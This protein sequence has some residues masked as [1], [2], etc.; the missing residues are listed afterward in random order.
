MAESTRTLSLE[1]DAVHAPGD[2]IWMGHSVIP[3]DVAC[4]EVT[5]NLPS[6]PITS[7]AADGDMRKSAFIVNDLTKHPDLCT[8]PYVTGYPNGRFYA[9]VP[10]TTSSGVNIGAYCI[11]D[12]K[13]RDGVSDEDLVFLRDM[14][15]TV[16]THLE[17]VRA[18]SERQQIN[19][20]V[21]G[22]GDFVR[23]ASDAGR[24]APPATNMP[25][26][27]QAEAPAVQ[28]RLPDAL[29]EPT[30]T[31]AA[32]SNEAITGSFSPGHQSTSSRDHPPVSKISNVSERVGTGDLPKST[33]PLSNYA[34]RPMFH[35]QENADD[36][37]GTY[38]R[39][40]EILCQSLDIDGVAFLDASVR[41]FGGLSEAQ[42]AESAESNEGST[43]GSEDSAGTL[44][45]SDSSNDSRARR[46]K[47]CPVLGCA[48][49][50][51][52]VATDASSTQ[53]RQSQKL[54][55]SFLRRLMSR[56]PRGKVWTFDENL[57]T[58]SEY[59]ASSDES[60]GGVRAAGLLSQRTQQRKAARKDR[61]S[62]A[63]RLQA[64]FPGSR[65]IALH[66]IWDF[67]RRRWAT[68]G[69][70]WTFDPLRL[71]AKETEMQFVAAFC[72]IIVAETK[73][74]EVLK[75][76]KAKSDFIS[77]VSHELRSP[78]HGILGSC[79]L[80]AEHGLDDTATS[81]LKQID[82]CGHTLL[83][84]IEHLLDF[85]NLKSQRLKKGA[86]KG[87]R[88]GRKAVPQIGDR[89]AGDLKALD[90]SVALDDVTEE[91]VLA[92]VTSFNY[93]RK[94]QEHTKTPVILDI[95][96]SGKNWQC[97]LATGGWK[98]VCINLV[99]NALKYTPSGFIRVSLKQEPKPGS[100]RR[101][102]AV[103]TVSD[104]GKGM[105][106]KFQSDSL[107]HSF[108]QED[109]LSDGLGL[110]MHL[111]SRIIYAMGG[112]IEVISDQDGTGTCVTV[113]VPLEHNQE[114]RHRSE[115][116]DKSN[117]VT[118]KALP[119]LKVG[120]VT[121]SQASA[122]PDPSSSAAVSAMVMAS[123]ENN[124]EYIGLQHE[125][126]ES[127]RAS[128]YDL[129]IVTEHNF[130]SH[131]STLRDTG[132][133]NHNG[134]TN[135]EN[136]PTI[137]I[138]F[139]KSTAQGLPDYFV[140]RDAD[141]KFCFR[142]PDVVMVTIALPCGIKQITRAISSA[143][144]LHRMPRAVRPGESWDIEKLKTGDSADGVTMFDLRAPQQPPVAQVPVKDIH[145]IDQAQAGA[146]QLP[147]GPASV[148][149]IR[150]SSARAQQDSNP[151]NHEE[152]STDAAKRLDLVSRHLSTSQP[153]PEAQ[154]TLSSAAKLPLLLLV[155][156]NVINLRIL[157]TI[158]KKS[159][160][161]HI[162]ATNGQL[163]VEAFENAHRSL[164]PNP[165]SLLDPEKAPNTGLENIPVGGGLPKIILMDINMPVMDGYEAVQK[166]RAYER[167]HRLGASKIIAVTALQSE[168]AQVEAFGSGFDMFLS[169]PIQMKKLVGLLE[170]C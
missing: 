167:K 153:V 15:Q 87:S 170:A 93:G 11:L 18:L 40:A 122:E 98:R 96:R 86:V 48:Q 57:K 101:F 16:M 61:K 146:A 116:R 104:T 156:D 95:D 2:E 70:Y 20:M 118:S 35:Q 108:A 84:I 76:D 47:V 30:R 13:V 130:A 37:T 34:T 17:T 112:K 9:G 81:Y 77:S 45:H 134:T 152:S 121:G 85:A 69:L 12:D 106:K 161:P 135:K 165:S 154:P 27:E 123:I 126:Y 142:S 168:A 157:M 128:P 8:R 160:Y 149:P 99:T 137:V 103:L 79:E 31:P 46:S 117:I 50:L 36:P 139:D 140:G 169:K 125:R 65:C 82:S 52:T 83:E 91:T 107:F 26:R 32:S 72:D 102:D 29:I 136:P 133:G 124:L 164:S 19:R 92:C 155:D 22:L 21:A 5:V 64:A 78:L 74:F 110:G 88:I 89:A 127:Q 113:R 115:I 111:V 132:A 166:I 129:V 60:G 144:H 147:S 143:L 148:L 73:R 7:D 97:S 24:E 53:G 145:N 42:D 66:G 71:I 43:A 63:E 38:Q 80:L 59:S 163:A 55:E 68:A 158:A 62:D 14:S 105:S 151:A 39:A 33:T 44:S 41:V 25:L 1:N 94:P 10:I 159:N 3:R 114:G 141:D 138:C 67:T 131:F 23:G 54:T 56:Y 28:Y 119:A 150:P 49:K 100:R 6:F 75:T 109:T 4:C 162:T 120:L 58:H 90:G 51:Q